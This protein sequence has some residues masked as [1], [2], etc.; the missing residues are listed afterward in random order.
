MKTKRYITF[1]KISYKRMVPHV[2]EYGFMCTRSWWECFKI[3]LRHI[4]KSQAT[5]FIIEKVVPKKKLHSH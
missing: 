1:Y 4:R 3:G 2:K 5:F